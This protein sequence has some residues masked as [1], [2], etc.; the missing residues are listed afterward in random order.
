MFSFRFQSF[1]WIC[2][3]LHFACYENVQTDA[4]HIDGSFDVIIE[5]SAGDDYNYILEDTIH[6]YLSYPANEGYPRSLRNKE[7]RCLILSEK[8]SARS[9][10]TVIPIAL[11]SMIEHG[12]E[13]NYIIAVPSEEKYVGIDIENFSDLVTK[14]NSVKNILE[15]WLLNRCGLGCS[16]YISW[17]DAHAAKFL[18]DKTSQSS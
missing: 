15:Y 16:E 4:I 10:I 11:F 7:L 12:K 18:L 3:V 5:H 17:Q 6:P 13:I 8:L 9:R 2:I 14:Y 1:I